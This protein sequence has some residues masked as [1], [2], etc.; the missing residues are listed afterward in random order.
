VKTIWR[1]SSSPPVKK[2]I[3]TAEDRK[4]YIV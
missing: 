1:N 3:R 2:P 4:I